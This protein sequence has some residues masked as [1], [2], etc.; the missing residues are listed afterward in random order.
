MF[1]LFLFL[2]ALLCRAAFFLQLKNYPLLD[3]LGS[4]PG[5]YYNKAV[6]I[7]R[8][9]DWVGSKIFFA[10]PFYPYFLATLFSIFG[11]ELFAARI[12]QGLIGSLTAIL[13]YLIGKRAFGQRVGFV[14]GILYCLYPVFPFYELTL[15]YDPLLLFH[16][17]LAIAV[18]F[19]LQDNWT[20]P[21]SL[22]LG[23]LVGLSFTLRPNILILLI[24]LWILFAGR[25]ANLSSSRL[26]VGIVFFGLGCLLIIFP[27]T[28][29]NYLVGGEWVLISAHGGEAFYTGNNPYTD[30]AIAKIPSVETDFAGEERDFVRLAFRK[31]GEKGYRTASHFW[32]REGFEFIRQHPSAYLRLLLKKVYRL[33]KAYEIPDNNDYQFTRTFFHPLARGW[34]HI[35]YGLILAL[36]VYGL[37]VGLRYSKEALFLFLYLVLSVSVS[38]LFPI[39]SRYRLPIVPVL[40]VF[41]A[42]TCCHVWENMKR[43]RRK[44]IFLSLLICVPVYLFSEWGVKEDA[45]FAH[46][47]YSLGKLRSGQGKSEEALYWYHQALSRFPSFSPV[48][49]SLAFEY[50][51]RGQRDAAVQN[52]K[53]ALRLDPD[54]FAALNNL[55]L[56]E[57]EGGD[58]PPALRH[59]QGAIRHDPVS[60]RARVVKAKILWKLGKKAK[61]IKSLKEV[62]TLARR[63]EN[64]PVSSYVSA[65]LQKWSAQEP[66]QGP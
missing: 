51:N 36:S 50:Q 14:A 34:S 31:T 20:I 25:G 40:I 13:V 55:A 12:V 8:S 45:A 56:L 21:R 5:Y 22:F 4:D 27:I 39:I 49:V 38:L 24:P 1:P 11:R 23:L 29:R 61:A 7:L 48:Y 37:A 10:S 44:I 54:S 19:G 59:I 30:S 26:L 28:L 52:Y 57:L 9:G 64:S 3:V 17:L 62:L 18:C 42:F 47:Y 6:E 53:K 65:I 16:M 66:A 46:S 60:L 43:G 58:F 63:T 32:Y 33:L 15:E 35:D 41:A 2:F